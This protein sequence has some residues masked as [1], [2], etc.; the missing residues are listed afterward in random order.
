MA[1]KKPGK[2]FLIPDEDELDNPVESLQNGSAFTARNL[3]SDQA[4][5]AVSKARLETDLAREQNVSSEG[6]GK[7]R[8]QQGIIDNNRDIDSIQNQNPDDKLTKQQEEQKEDGS[9]DARHRMIV[10]DKDS[11]VSVN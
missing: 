4:K 9:D 3:V 8:N 1:R 11:A 2:R 6:F 7:S 5:S 10:Y